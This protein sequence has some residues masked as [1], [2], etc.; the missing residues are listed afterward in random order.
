[1]LSGTTPLD[2]LVP[3]APVLRAFDAEPIALTDV[4][5]LQWSYEIAASDV[6]AMYPPAL[7]PTLPPMAMFVVWSVSDSPWGAFNLA[8]LRLSCRSGARPRGFLVSAV[9]DNVEA[10]AALAEHWGLAA[11]QG[12]VSVDRHYDAADV[13]VAVDGETVLAVRGDDP[14]LLRPSDLQ[15]FATMHAARTAAGL[16]LVQFDPSWEVIRAE[17]YTPV[18]EVFDADAW[19]QPRLQPTWPVVAFGAS[20]NGTLSRPRFATRPDVTAFEGTERLD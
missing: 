10:C 9:I 18:L 15:F 12:Q 4:E 17:R 16:R 2:T 13:A 1:M 6:V 11:A 19:G 7:H 8:Q 3:N 5:M 14:D 20:G